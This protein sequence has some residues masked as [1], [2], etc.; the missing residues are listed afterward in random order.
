MQQLGDPLPGHNLIRLPPVEPRRMQVQALSRRT[1]WDKVTQITLRSRTLNRRRTALAATATLLLSV[2]IAG[3]GSAATGPG[4]ITGSTTS[5]SCFASSDGTCS[6]T[7]SA[8]PE[9]AFSASAQLSSPDSPLSRSGRYSLALARYTLGFDLPAAARE[10]SITVTLQLDDA[11]ASWVQ[12]LPQTFGGTR[13]AS[14]GAKVLFQ[15]FGHEAPAECGCGWPSQ[16]APDVVVTRA[17]EVGAANSVSD[18]LV[19]LTMTARN[20][21]GDNMLPAGHYELLLRGYAL[22]DLFGTGDWGTLNAAMSGHIEDVT[23]SIPAAAS[24]LTLSATGKGSNRVLTA[25]LTD[26][27]SAPISGRTIS[28]YS[29]G[30]LLGTSVTT[31]DGVATFTLGGKLRGGSRVFS[32]V[33]AGDDS[34]AASMAETRS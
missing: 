14:S 31:S 34:Y 3:P 6:T 19:Q 18:T 30:D 12:D 21:F 28:F 11:S 16:G 29:G 22:T 10:A 8:S 23:V 2:L 7:A 27:D 26:A 20:P 17:A 32:A 9:G 13:S 5:E 33:F 1:K 4:T 25:V 15:L 24:S